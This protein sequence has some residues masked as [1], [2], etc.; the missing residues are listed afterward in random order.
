MVGRYTYA[1]SPFFSNNDRVA[2]SNRVGDCQIGY[3]GGIGS[4]L[5]QICEEK[6][7]NMVLLNEIDGETRDSARAWANIYNAK[8]R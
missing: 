1:S 2:Q 6:G 4:E 3:L 8:S 5:L 7:I